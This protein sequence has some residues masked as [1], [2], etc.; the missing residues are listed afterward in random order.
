MESRCIFTEAKLEEDFGKVTKELDS[1]RRRKL[2]I[3][4]RKIAE[5]DQYFFDKCNRLWVLC[6]DCYGRFGVR[7]TCQLFSKQLLI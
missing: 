6:K 4:K 5:K 1:L 3:L 7:Q 2:D